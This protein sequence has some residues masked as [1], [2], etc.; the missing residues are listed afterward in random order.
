MR[1]EH[2]GLSG[3]RAINRMSGSTRPGKDAATPI[4]SLLGLLSNNAGAPLLV[5]WD[6]QGAGLEPVLSPTCLQYPSPESLL[7]FQTHLLPTR[8]Q[9]PNPC[10]THSPQGFPLSS[11]VSTL[12]PHFRGHREL[13]TWVKLLSNMG[14]GRR[15][16]YSAIWRVFCIS[17]RMGTHFG[18]SGGGGFKNFHSRLIMV[19]RT[20]GGSV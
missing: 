10:S 19:A 12:L 1:L 4:V 11:G 17:P 18:G 15:G 7:S 2:S 16:R 8:V 13:G 14:S 9:I 5:T 20:A 6:S 3:G